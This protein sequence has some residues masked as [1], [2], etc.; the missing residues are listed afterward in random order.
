M[1]LLD[2][3]DGRLIWSEQFDEKAADILKVQD[4]IS[5]RVVKDLAVRV[6]DDE[7]QRFRKRSTEST[8]AFEHYIKGRIYLNQ[9]NKTSGEKALESFSHAVALDP[10]YAP[11]Y[12]GLSDVYSLASDNFLMP[13]IAMPKAREF[14]DKALALDDSLDEAHLSMAYVRWWGDWDSLAAEAEFKR[15]LELNPSIGT[16]HLEYGR[17][18]TQLSRFEEALG[19]ITIAQDSDPQSARIRYELGWM[20]YCARQYDRAINLYE[21]ALR[22][23][24]NSAQTHRRMAL[25]YAQKGLL[26]EAIAELGKALEIRE[27]A[28]YYSDL[29]WIHAIRGEKSEVRNSLTKLQEITKQKRRYVS[30]YYEARIHAGLGDK[31]Q[32]FQLLEKAYQDRSDRLLELPVDPIFDSIRTEPRFLALIHRVGFVK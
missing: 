16:V 30:P 5:E 1:R 13:G 9:A 29:G 7:R 15:A 17:F 22:M 27:D 6:T 10:N 3:K 26:K 32:V 14:A 20:Y 11:A 2:T 25:A 21:E 28:S 23:D 18:L 8:E 31:E 24:T 19:Q 12:S 4:S